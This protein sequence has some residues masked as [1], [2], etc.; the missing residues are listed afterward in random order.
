[1]YSTALYGGPT[2]NDSLSVGVSYAEE[3][4]LLADYASYLL[5][6]STGCLRVT[7]ADLF[8]YPNTKAACEDDSSDLHEVATHALD[9]MIQRL[10]TESG[11]MAQDNVSAIGPASSR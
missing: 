9:P 8:L 3:G 5:F 4:I 10:I 7:A 6:E 1:M 11:L 2:L